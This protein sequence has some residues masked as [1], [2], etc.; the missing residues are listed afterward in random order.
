MSDYFKNHIDEDRFHE[1]ENKD[2][3]K[4]KYA[5]IFSDS[6][7]EKEKTNLSG[8]EQEKAEAEEKTPLDYYQFS[9]NDPN[10]DIKDIHTDYKAEKQRH[11]Q[12][13]KDRKEI[14]AGNSGI[15]K[16]LVL[17][18]MALALGITAGLGFLA[19]AY[20]GRPIL[21]ADIERGNHRKEG[22]TEISEATTSTETPVQN[23]VNAYKG[24]Q[25]L[26]DVS[27]IVKKNKPAMVNISATTKTVLQ[28]F[29]R[30]AYYQD[31]PVSGSGFIISEDDDNYYIATNHHV[32]DN[33]ENLSVAFIDN[34]VAPAVVK[35][36]DA[37]NDLAVI[38]VSK[39]DVS[40]ETQKNVKLVEIGDSENLVEGQ[41]VIAMGNALGYGQSTTVG[42]ISALDRSIETEDGMTMEHLIQTDAAINF[43]NSGGALI[44]AAGRVIGINSAKNGAAAVEGMGYAIP[45]SKAEPI[46]SNI[47]KD[48]RT[49]VAEE[50]RGMLGVE[51]ESSGE[52]ALQSYGIPIGF[53]IKGI[54]KGAGAEKAGIIKG[55]VIVAING[56]KVRTQMDIAERLQFFEV[57]ESVEVTI[58]RQI[59]GEYKEL[60]KD[61]VLSEKDEALLK[62]ERQ[63][64][65]WRENREN[66]ENQL[67]PNKEDGDEYNN[68][69]RSPD[70]DY[71]DRLNG[72]LEEMFGRP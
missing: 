60:K 67:F 55:D 57:G 3:Q 47:L 20:L 51:G 4:Q 13:L 66:Q 14:P 29:F 42:V 40:S 11:K 31:V 38:S 65:E 56:F 69:S 27:E 1:D 44:D 28:D 33:G 70:E 41:A 50:K 32:I 35:G 25:V 22:T 43:G 71:R 17:T 7:I 6:S 52:D 72:L 45:I 34:S 9:N 16:F 18:M 46:I 49:P 19:T 62:Q 59:D 15:K 2:N 12:L 10:R 68:S 8:F 24:Y 39:K 61:V 54:R 58:M 36:K 63:Q 30:G 5:D 48:D 64:K 26:N 53:F 37:Y 21:K 23:S